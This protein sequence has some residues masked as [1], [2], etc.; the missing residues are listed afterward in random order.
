MLT[1]TLAALDRVMAQRD[2][3]QIMALAVCGVA[4]VGYVD[5]LTGLQVSLSLFYLG[6]IALAAWYV[7]R[8]PGVCIAA[9]SC[10]GWYIADAEHQ[11]ASLS[12]QIWNAMVRLEV[13]LVFALVLR[14]L[15]DHVLE[16]RLLARTDSLTELFGRRAFLE[17]LEHDLA[18]A[19]RRNGA[20]SLAYID[21]DEFKT[22]NDTYGHLEGD[23]LLRT[24]GRVLRHS[25]RRTDTAARLGGDEFALILPDTDSDGAHEVV[26]N[27]RKKFEEAFLSTGFKISCSIGV[28]TCVD[29]TLSPERAI[30]A[31]DELMY[32]V[33]RT[34]KA[35]VAY[36]VL[37][38]APLPASAH[39]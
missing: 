22:V 9:L 27:L 6:P 1:R 33:K 37:G 10:I 13:F 3:G 16:E 36:R 8:W 38:E 34:G 39:A 24:I 23:R 7:G 29:A 30:A 19:Q 17:T 2:A 5:F 35:S 21:L 18:L 15:R 11:Y 25:A 14:S 12:I 26:R 31:A 4:A 32:H 20:I 28:V